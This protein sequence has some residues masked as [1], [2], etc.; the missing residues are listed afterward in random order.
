[1]KLTRYQKELAA[2][3]GE[4]YPGL[5]AVDLVA[6][7]CR[8]GVVDHT[9]CKVM[10]VRHWV[11]EAVKKGSRKVEAMW[12]ASEHFCSSYEYVRK[13]MYYYNDVNI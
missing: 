2:I 13:C 9:L 4:K 6:E 5:S 11:D 12:M 10:A 7:L 3:V 1:M 8:M